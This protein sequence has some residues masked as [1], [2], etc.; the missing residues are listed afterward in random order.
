MLIS[1]ICECFNGHD[2]G[3][4]TDIDDLT[5]F[6]DYR[7]PQNVSKREEL[8]PFYDDDEI[9]IRTEFLLGVC[10]LVN[11]INENIP[12]EKDI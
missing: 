5:M 6:A 2:L 3:H 12:L 11:Q 10:Y 7:V 4:F 9:E 1:D 8:I